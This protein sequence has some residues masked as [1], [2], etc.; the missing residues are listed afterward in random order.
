MPLLRT[1][2]LV[3]RFGGVVALDGVSIVVEPS[4]LTL[5]IGPN[6]SGKSTLINVI[7]GVYKPD[8][9][10]VFLEER[11][12]TGWPPHIVHRAGVARTFQIP[13]P[14]M[15]MTVLE[16]LLVAAN[17]MW[18][19]SPLSAFLHR[20]SWLEE[21]AK[22]VERAFE[23]LGLLDLEHMWNRRA[24]ELS[25]GQLKLLEIGRALMSAPRLVLLD[26][27]VAGVNPKLA[28]VIMDHV[29]KL[30]DELG[31]AFLLVEHRLDIVIPYVDY[32]YAMFKGRIMEEGSPEQVLN[33][34]SVLK[35]YLGG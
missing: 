35:A 17:W 14:F 5:L 9:G 23:V 32:A 12:I 34:G 4:S 1:E 24:C 29:L 22:H 30:R 13:E 11:D 21:E 26:E 28:R 10:R 2:E 25:G 16:N 7:S 31:V 6:G 15:R 8:S 3:K 18:G 19:E 33:S 27:P 20:R